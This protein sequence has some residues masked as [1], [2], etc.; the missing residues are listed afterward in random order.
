MER[1]VLYATVLSVKPSA[2]KEGI[3]YI[4]AQ[5]QGFGQVKFATTRKVEVGDIVAV[6]SQKLRAAYDMFRWE[7]VPIYVRYGEGK[8]KTFYTLKQAQAFSDNKCGIIY[9]K[10]M[11]VK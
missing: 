3:L 11:E 9:I 2:V 5:A 4:T 6:R 7:Q 10:P 8:Q 1:I